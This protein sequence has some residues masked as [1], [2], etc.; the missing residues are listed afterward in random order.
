MTVLCL[1]WVVY[2]QISSGVR[3]KVQGKRIRKG[4]WA[5]PFPFLSSFPVTFGNRSAKSVRIRKKSV[6]IRKICENP[7]FRAY[8]GD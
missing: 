6:E 2:D 3:Q 1:Y 8:I 7:W 5:F 4:K